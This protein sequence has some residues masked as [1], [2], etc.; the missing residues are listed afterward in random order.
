MQTLL[1]VLRE[2]ETWIHRTWCT[3]SRL[4]VV[5]GVASADGGEEQ[6]GQ[7]S[8]H[9]DEALLPW[10]PS[11]IPVTVQ[12][13][14]REWNGLQFMKDNNSDFEQRNQEHLH[15]L[16]PTSLVKQYK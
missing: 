10:W 12:I 13:T 15:K 5:S 4:D 7:Y 9:H 8:R 2:G 14:V 1:C 16:K 11:H 3:G 6:E